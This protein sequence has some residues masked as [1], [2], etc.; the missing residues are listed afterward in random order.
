MVEKNTGINQ[1]EVNDFT[2]P[3]ESEVPKERTEEGFV[4]SKIVGAARWLR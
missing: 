2:S 4:P 1:D 3:W